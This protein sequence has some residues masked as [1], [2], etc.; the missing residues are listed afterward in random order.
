MSGR[1]CYPGCH[2][3]RELC[4]SFPGAQILRYAQDDRPYVCKRADKLDK[5]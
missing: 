1:T 2:P 3:E 5:G 4:I